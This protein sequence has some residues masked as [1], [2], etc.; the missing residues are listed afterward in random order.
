[1]EGAGF[2]LF[3][4]PTGLGADDVDGFGA[5]FAR[6]S[7]ALLNCNATSFLL[8][9]KDSLSCLAKARA[10]ARISSGSSSSRNWTPLLR[11]ALFGRGSWLLV[12]VWLTCLAELVAACAKLLVSFGA[13]ASKSFFL[14]PEN[15]TFV[16]SLGSLLLYYTHR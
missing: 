8:F 14:P 12:I 2:L 10:S 1:M 6:P 4:A 15:L 11:V 3:F 13:D 16:Q 7:F 9:L 5:C